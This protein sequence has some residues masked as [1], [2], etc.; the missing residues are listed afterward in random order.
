MQLRVSVFS[1]IATLLALSVLI[2]VHAS[3]PMPATRE[4]WEES[5]T[6][7][8]EITPATKTKKTSSTTKTKKNKKEKVKKEK[9]QKAKKG[10]PAAVDTRQLMAD[11]YQHINAFGIPEHETKLIEERGGAPTYGEI[12]PESLATI[13][14]DIGVTNK[15]VF[16]DLG[17]GSG[18]TVIQAYLEF[19]FKK[20]V[21]VEL[22]EK[23]YNYALEVLQVLRQRDL[24]DP[25]R[26]IEFILGDFAEVPFDGA[27]VIYMCSTCYSNELMEKL[28]EKFSHLKK[29]LHVVSLKQIPNHASYGL[30]LVKEYRLPMT[31]SGPEGSPVSIYK[32]TKPKKAKKKR[33]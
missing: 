3:N 18:K 12:K 1:S 19:P 32:L 6:T 27:T 25:A 11:M 20:V 21:G 16:Y 29:G 14:N 9:K 4:E 13:F 10:V 15:D 5:T 17:S 8:Y 24:V 30:E 26:P 23:R 22:S 33:A 7:T 28:A 2:C 31:W